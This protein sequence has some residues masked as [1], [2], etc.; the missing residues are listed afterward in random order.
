MKKMLYGLFLVVILA[1]CTCRATGLSSK[2]YV[3][4]DSVNEVPIVIGFDTENQRYFGSVVNR[5]FGNYR[6]DGD[7]L[8]LEPGWRIVTNAR[9]SPQS[10]G[11]CLGKSHGN[12]TVPKV[13][14]M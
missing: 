5:Y 12:T 4:I 9:R 2:E 10:K 11:S 7:E 14:W 6:V 3:L 13:G 8:I 1:A